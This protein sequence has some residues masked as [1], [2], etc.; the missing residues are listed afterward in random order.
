MAAESHSGLTTILDE[1]RG[2]DPDARNRLL[3]KVYDELRRMA[4][5]LLR[6]QR[7]D[8]TLRPSDVVGEAYLRLF[9]K[10]FLPENREHFFGAAA[11]A[12]REVVVEHARRRGS[13]KR[14]AGFERLPLDDVV[15]YFERQK[16]EIEEVREALD[17]LQ[18]IRPRQSQVLTLRYFFCYSIREI[19]ALLGISEKTVRNDQQFARAWLRG[20]LCEHAP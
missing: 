13:R 3:Q 12:M 18:M 20:Q 19:A 5:R 16:L 15:D 6:G 8:F 7:P 2:G 14:G 17:R 9:G 11:K 10:N 4:A 1:L